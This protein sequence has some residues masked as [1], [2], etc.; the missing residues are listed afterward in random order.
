MAVRRPRTAAKKPRE[1]G[2]RV[3][4]AAA[5]ASLV[6]A[7]ALGF[8]WWGAAPRAEQLFLRSTW[9]RLDAPARAAL[10]LRSAAAGRLGD[11]LQPC[12][13]LLEPAAFAR[14][15]TRVRGAMASVDLRGG[16]MCTLGEG[17]LLTVASVRKQLGESSSGRPRLSQ[18]VASL[19]DLVQS[20]ADERA[21]L[22]LLLM[23]E[24]ARASS[25]LMP[26]LQALLHRAH[27][28]IP[29][30]WD[31]SSAEGAERRAELERDAGPRT[32]RAADELRRVISAHYTALVP[33]ALEQLPTLLL[34]GVVDAEY[35][36]EQRFIEFWLSIRSR[37]FENNGFGV[38]VP[39]ACLLNH[40]PTHEPSNVE[41]QYVAQRN[42]F[43]MKAT[44]HIK[45]GEELT[46]SYGS[47]LCKERALLVYG[48]VQDGMPSCPGF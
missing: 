20:A 23:R 18:E 44:R 3:L 33:R 12:A 2:G 1:G 31:P 19:G 14:G 47:N 41:L 21:L 11:G 10:Y 29:S 26:Y 24:D 36:S 8:L 38:L 35:Y 30:A 25:P 16:E 27:E 45:Q 46:Y 7:G 4:A 9:A 15:G 17:A 43:V 22:A 39:L 32:L 40:P 42:G 48:F 34:D 6:I 28:H 37:S 5:L 13:G